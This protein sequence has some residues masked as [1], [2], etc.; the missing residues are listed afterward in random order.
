MSIENSNYI[1]EKISIP[2]FLVAS[3]YKTATTD[4]CDECDRCMGEQ[5]DPCGTGEW[6]GECDCQGWMCGED[7]GKE[8][9]LPCDESDW[10][11]GTPCGGLGCTNCEE[12]C[13]SIELEAYLWYW[14]ENEEREKAYQAVT[15][16]GKTQDFSY[17]VWNDMIGCVSSARALGDESS[18]NSTYLSYDDTCMSDSDKKLTAERFNSLWYNIESLEGTD[19]GIDE[20][21]TGNKVYGEYF[22]TLMSEINSYLHDII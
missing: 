21:Q 13:M 3:S 12:S 8:P 11:G 20:Q 9:I 22:T 2:S 14:D 7:C 16:K 17:D 15:E 1:E 18:W 19:T 6:C 4:W 10:P 5:G